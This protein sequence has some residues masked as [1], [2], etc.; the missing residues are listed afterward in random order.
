MFMRSAGCYEKRFF[1]EKKLSV[2]TPSRKFK[3]NVTSI[4]DTKKH[5]SQREKKVCGVNLW[6]C[7]FGFLGN[8]FTHIACGVQAEYPF[9]V[10]SPIAKIGSPENKSNA[11]TT[12]AYACEQKFSAFKIHACVL[13]IDARE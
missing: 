3:Q 5:L 13:Y 2:K 4:Q 11:C 7:L 12:K 6:A 9:R 8:V 10:L 1:F